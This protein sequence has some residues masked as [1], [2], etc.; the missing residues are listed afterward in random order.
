MGACVTEM[1]RFRDHHWY[2]ADELD[3][4]T[5]QAQS[6]GVTTLVTTE[7]DAVRLPPEVRG[8]VTVLTV[9]VEWQEEAALNALLE[10]LLG[11]VAE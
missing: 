10:P 6:L 3:A 5:R 4:L 8:A 7:K 9:T 1:K 2:S 11:Q